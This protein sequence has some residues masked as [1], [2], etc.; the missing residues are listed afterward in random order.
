VVKLRLRRAGKKKHPFYKVVAADMRSPRDGRYIEAV[1]SYDPQRHPPELKFRDERI[2]YWLRKGAQPTDTVRSLFRRS[3]IW[4]RWTLLK[5]GVEESVMQ[6]I[7]ERWNMQQQ[8]RAKR[9]ADRKARRTERKK[10]A[11]KEQPKAEAA[12]A[13][14]AEPPAGQ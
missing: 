8:D 13:A 6:K 7:I 12:P 4:L 1:G 9:D 3:G 14:V 5:R 10:K 11:A 2:L